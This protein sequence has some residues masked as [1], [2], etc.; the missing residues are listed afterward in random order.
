MDEYMK[1]LLS[2]VTVK[3]P[4]KTDDNKKYYNVLYRVIGRPESKI[5]IY[6][7]SHIIRLI[8][9]HNYDLLTELKEWNRTTSVDFPTTDMA[10]KKFFY[11]LKTPKLSNRDLFVYEEVLRLLPHRTDFIRKQTFHGRGDELFVEMEMWLGTDEHIESAVKLYVREVIKRTKDEQYAIN[12]LFNE[13]GWQLWDQYIED[14]YGSKKKF[15]T[16][17][18]HKSKHNEQVLNR[19]GLIAKYFLLETGDLVTY[20]KLLEAEDED[21]FIQIMLTNGNVD[22]ADML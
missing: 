7:A 17:F 2:N 8:K 22:V 19:L 11:F 5:G 13:F 20:R 18:L 9:K 21:T 3:K 14:V 16:D 15:L 10:M 6:Y 4:E 1:D 12:N